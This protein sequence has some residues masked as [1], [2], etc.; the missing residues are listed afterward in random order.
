MLKLTPNPDAYP[1]LRL[2]VEAWWRNHRRFRFRWR[3]FISGMVIVFL[4]L[5]IG[6]PFVL[7]LGGPEIVSPD[8]LS[9]PDGHF[10]EVNG[11][12]LY[13][14]HVPAD[15]EAVILLHGFGGSTQSWSDTIPAL[16]DA[17]YNVYALDLPGFGLSEKG[18][19]GDYSHDAQADHVIQF[20]D[21]QH[22]EQAV[23]IGHSMGGNIAAHIALS[24][25]ERVNK[26][27]LVDA[28]IL[29]ENRISVPPVL[30]KLPFIQRWAQIGLRRALVPFIGD[31]LRDAVYDDSI[32]TPELEEAYKR[33][34]HTPGWDL[35]LLGIVRDQDRNGLP[36]PV[37]TIQTP[38][39][40]LWGNEDT[41]INTADATRLAELMPN[42]QAVLF[43]NVGHL[44]MH[45]VPAMFNEA[46]ISFLAE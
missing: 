40:I 7:P 42:A 23:I 13:Y 11:D 41:W 21:S 29:T 9:D 25:P 6:L 19:D 5:I 20:M 3:W 15:G 8:S 34:L 14:V 18:W 37:S 35:G 1:R 10:I 45:E 2:S 38:T 30:L 22:I 17:G 28:A 16:A 43:E 36:A 12:T 33:P 26:L 27:V 32:I 39:L 4:F 44:P 46:L 24:H 31:L